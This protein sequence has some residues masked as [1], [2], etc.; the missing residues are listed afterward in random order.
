M[1]TT[2]SV[3]WPAFKI[4]FSNDFRGECGYLLVVFNYL[5]TKK[6]SIGIE[7]LL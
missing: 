4:D 2:S 5:P 3:P 7:Q 1:N 6:K